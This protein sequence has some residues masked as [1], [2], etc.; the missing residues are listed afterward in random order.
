M[1]VTLYLEKHHT[2]LVFAT[3]FRLDKY[4]F[5]IFRR[6]SHSDCELLTPRSQALHEKLVVAQVVNT[7]PV[8]Y[9]V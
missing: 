1:W 5:Y 2:D 8:F 4:L 7:F 3:E 9:G 6:M